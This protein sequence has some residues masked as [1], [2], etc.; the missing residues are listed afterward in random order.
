MD[1]V[2]SMSTGH[3]GTTTLSLGSSYE[4]L[5]YDPSKCYFGFETLAQGVRDF[6]RRFDIL[7]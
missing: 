1:F 5:G 4:E 2:F 3:C 6:A 7:Y